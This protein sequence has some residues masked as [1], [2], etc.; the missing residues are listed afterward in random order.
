MKICLTYLIFFIIYVIFRSKEKS[1]IYKSVFSFIDLLV[2]GILGLVELKIMLSV[3]E[4]V[5][6]PA[7][8]YILF[9]MNI[10]ILILARK[11]RN[12][13]EE[14]TIYG[15]ISYV[16]ERLLLSSALVVIILQSF[17][18]INILLS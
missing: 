10:I 4:K 12:K 1:N 17:T 14:I 11:I 2:G 16:T 8:F 18:I 9:A 7:L 3:M 5:N 6:L 13:L 15:E